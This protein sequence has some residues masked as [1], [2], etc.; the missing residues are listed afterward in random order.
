MSGKGGGLGVL[1]WGPVDDISSAGSQRKCVVGRE[2]GAAAY[3]E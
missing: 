3:V 2:V 1:Q